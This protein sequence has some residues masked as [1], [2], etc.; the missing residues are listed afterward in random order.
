MCN[1]CGLI[2]KSNKNLNE[3]IQAIHEAPNTRDYKC[4][5]CGKEY[6]TLRV[7]S[8]HKRYTHSKY[9]KISCEKCGKLFTNLKTLS[10]HIKLVHDKVKPFKCEFCDSTFGRNDYLKS[11][12]KTHFSDGLKRRRGRKL[13]NGKTLFNI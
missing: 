9:E 4:D 8:K 7:L 11:H 13:S 12:T 3:H 5:E 2:L 1:I 6:K 10:T